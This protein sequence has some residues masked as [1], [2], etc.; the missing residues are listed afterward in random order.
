MAFGDP[1]EAPIRCD[2]LCTLFISVRNEVKDGLEHDIIG[3]RLRRTSKVCDQA[4]NE[5]CIKVVE[6]AFGRNVGASANM[7][8]RMPE[9]QRTSATTALFRFWRLKAARPS[10]QVYRSASDHRYVCGGSLRTARFDIAAHGRQRRSGKPGRQPHQPLASS[11]AA[12]KSRCAE[13]SA[14]P[15][16]RRSQIPSA[17][18]PLHASCELLLS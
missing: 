5:L 16:S 12:H 13:P 4:K 11:S 8:Y 6:A 7:R 18:A 10:P 1:H 2:F 3:P 15:V 14:E 17:A 9:I